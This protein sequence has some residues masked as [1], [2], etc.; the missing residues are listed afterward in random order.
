MA[1][2]TV[3]VDNFPNSGSREAVALEIW[4]RICNANQSEDDML[5]LYARCLEATRSGGRYWEAQFKNGS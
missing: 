1:D 3:R 5:K 4:K 2:Q